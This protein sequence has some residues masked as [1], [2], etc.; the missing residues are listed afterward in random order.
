MHRLVKQEIKSEDISNDIEERLK[1][2]I[3]DNTFERNI[4]LTESCTNCNNCKCDWC[5]SSH[6]LKEL[7]SFMFTHNISFSR[8]LG[9]LESNFSYPKDSNDTEEVK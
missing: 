2:V 3:F 4:F 5:Y 7:V 9:I 1:S 8:A 6:I